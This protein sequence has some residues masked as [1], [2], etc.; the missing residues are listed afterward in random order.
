MQFIQSG[1]LNINFDLKGEGFPLVLI[2][3]FSGNLD[4]WDNELIEELS[5][6]YKVLI[7]DSRGAGRTVTPDEG[8]FTMRMFADDIAALMSL[9]GIDK[10]NILGFSLGG[11][12]AQ[13][14]VLNYPEKVN[15]LILC[16]TFCGSKN[17][18]MPEPEVINAMME[19]SGGVQG[20]FNNSLYFMFSDSYIKNNPDYF[21]DFRERFMKAPITDINARRQF[22]AG[23]KANT[24]DRLQDIAIPVLIM[25]GSDDKLVPAQNSQK[26]SER[27]KRSKFI[28]YEGAGHGFMTQNRESFL[29]DLIKF[30]DD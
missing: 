16:S 13:E 10:A 15:R 29:K 30:L 9:L 20:Q 2:Q 22:M 23:L 6:R 27:I 11:I 12:M 3:G 21:N 1:D 24:Y 17:M 7:F 14:L 25:T 26:I 19:K 28:K 4:W 8:D 5:M 18:I